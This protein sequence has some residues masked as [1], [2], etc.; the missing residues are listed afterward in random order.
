MRC[1][2][3][4]VGHL[5]NLSVNDRHF[6]QLPD[7]CSGLWLEWKGMDCFEIVPHGTIFP[8]EVGNWFCR[9]LLEPFRNKWPLSVLVKFLSCVECLILSKF[10]AVS[11]LNGVCILT[12]TVNLC[13]CIKQCP[14]KHFIEILLQKII[15]MGIKLLIWHQCWHH[16]NYVS[17]DGWI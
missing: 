15:V 1:W 9:F 4:V 10:K 16:S 3:I 13:S 2:K 12:Q 8:Q 17:L 7:P 11:S 14:A 5:Q 6:L